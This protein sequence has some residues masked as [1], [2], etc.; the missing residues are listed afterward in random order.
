MKEQIA[1]IDG[2]FKIIEKDL[3][4]EDKESS[5]NCDDNERQKSQ[6]FFCIFLHCL[7]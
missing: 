1:N 4:A 3:I 7:F 2:C 5:S 6:V